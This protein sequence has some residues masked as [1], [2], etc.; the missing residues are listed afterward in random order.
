MKINTVKSINKSAVPS[1]ELN[2]YIGQYDSFAQNII[3][4]TSAWLH[5]YKNKHNWEVEDIFNY[6]SISKD[7]TDS[8]ARK[9]TE[10]KLGVESIV[11]RSVDERLIMHALKDLN[12]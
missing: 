11:K 10:A 9:E 4:L 3:N 8:D 2:C 7:D 12:V 6:S 1:F 5:I